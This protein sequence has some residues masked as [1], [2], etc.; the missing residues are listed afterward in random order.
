M[1][2][3]IENKSSLELPGTIQI[4]DTSSSR[5]AL[6]GIIEKVFALAAHVT[7]LLGV[8]IKEGAESTA[9]FAG[10]H[11]YLR[12][13]RRLIFLNVIIASTICRLHD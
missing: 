12:L 13:L 2:K 5:R 3:R 6:I 10:R 1:D 9:P 4:S 11:D 8:G 7:D